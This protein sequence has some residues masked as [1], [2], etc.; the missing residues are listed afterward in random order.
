[1]FTLFYKK[2]Y[3]CNFHC[4]A[5]NDKAATPWRSDRPSPSQ[6]TC[7]GRYE[8]K[9]QSPNPSSLKKVETLVTSLTSV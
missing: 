6:V 4:I 3:S 5:C 8:K 2:V 7:I 1:M 9:K